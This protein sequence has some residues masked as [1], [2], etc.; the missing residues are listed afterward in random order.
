MQKSWYIVYTK[1]KC[2]KKVAGILAKKKV[3]NFSPLNC[4]RVQSLRR[5]KLIYEPLFSSYVF[6][7]IKESDISLITGIDNV[8]SILYWKGKA[9]MV[10]DQEIMA[11]REFVTYHQNIRL[12]KSRLNVNGEARSIDSSSYVMDGKILMIKNKSANVNLPSLGYTMVA[13]MQVSNDRE[14]EISFGNKE[15]MLNS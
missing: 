15:L 4:I 13:E 14:L 8:I 10:S 12:E 6:V 1:P 3:E 9:A 7:N 11:I 2:E 5:S